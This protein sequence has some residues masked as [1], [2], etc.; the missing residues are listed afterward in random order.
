MTAPAWN[1]L[2]HQPQAFFELSDEFDRK[3]LKRAY[4]RLLKKYKPEK[5]PA[6][7]QKIRAA[8]E[9]LDDQLRY[10]RKIAAASLLQA[11]EWSDGAAATEASATTQANEANSRGAPSTNA[12]PLH[13]RLK[14]ES[15]A[16]LYR[17]LAEKPNK[18]PYDFFALALLSDPVTKKSTTFVRWLLS[19]LKD[20][21]Q[22]LGLQSLLREYL[23]SRIPIK[24]LPSILNTLSQVIGSDQ[25]YF[26][27]E[28]TWKRFIREAG[29]E[30]FQQTLASCEAN[31]KGFKNDHR[32]TFYMSILRPAIWLGDQRWVQNVFTYLENEADL[33]H[34]AIEAEFM[35]LDALRRH[36]SL[37]NV[38]LDG[39]P[40]RQ[41]I[42][43]EMYNY[44]CSPGTAADSQI[45]AL[46]CQLAGN[47]RQLLDAFPFQRNHDEE[48][49][50]SFNMYTVWKIIGDE[51]IDRNG[52]EQPPAPTKDFKQQ[53]YGLLKDL[54]GD[55][56]NASIRN[57]CGW[58][59]VG[60][61]FAVAL[62]V[63]IVLG[64]ATA[65]VPASFPIVSGVC[66]GI[67]VLYHSYLHQRTLG[68][69][70]NNILINKIF[71]LY[72]LQWRTRFIQLLEGYQVGFHE[73]AYAL[74]DVIVTKQ[75]RLEA[76]TFLIDCIPRD[77]GIAFFAEAV[78]FRH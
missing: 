59:H 24:S 65:A 71:N 62:C 58:I 78:R 46:Q 20:H 45:I 43:A 30:T 47:A 68:R 23:Q 31:L 52:I 41:A 7:F 28:R 16:A 2:P 72:R 27:T 34:P 42:D 54:E 10:G 26:L 18:S 5:H 25:F 40:C 14:S 57:V 29:F 60:A 53:L 64:I 61:Y 50:T 69:L 13:E 17:E 9:A 12:A 74:R 21:P 66:L 36:V 1:L 39:I 51:V 15:P 19:G 6:E 33:N 49:E 67:G 55:W 77:L 44:C 48:L 11:Y 4:N 32:V 37:R 35:F 76:S 56:E 63:L 75:N 38:V 70:T 8:F 3:A 22:D 73:L